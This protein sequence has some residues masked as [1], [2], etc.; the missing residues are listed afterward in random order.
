MARCLSGLVA[1]GSSLLLQLGRGSKTVGGN[2]LVNAGNGSVLPG[3]GVAAARPPVRA[4][5]GFD[6]SPGSCWG[7]DRGASGLGIPSLFVQP[8]GPRRDHELL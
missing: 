6:Q 2:V 3:P 7:G 1:R 5:L 4:T 8:E